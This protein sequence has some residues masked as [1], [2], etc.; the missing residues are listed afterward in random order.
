MSAVIVNPP[1]DT[2]LCGKLTDERHGTGPTSFVI[3]RC[4]LAVG[5]TPPCEPHEFRLEDFSVDGE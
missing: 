4:R 1:L 2:L 5:H 3:M